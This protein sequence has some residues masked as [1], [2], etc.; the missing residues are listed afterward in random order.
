[1][2]NK[3]PPILVTVAVCTRERPKMLRQLLETVTRLQPV[4]GVKVHVVVVEN[5]P[6]IYGSEVVA[7]FTDR[8]SISY[9]NEPR[10]GLVF[11]RNT[12]VKKSLESGAEWI[13]FVDD[14]ER[15]DE[16][17]LCEMVKAKNTFSDSRAFAGPMHK[18]SAENATRWYPRHEP[19]SLKTGTETWDVTTG[20]LFFNQSIFASD[21]LGFQFDESFN[22]SGGEDTDIFLR[23]HKIGVKIRWVQNAVCEEDVVPERATFNARCSLTIRYMHIFGR[24]S[25]KRFGPILGRFHCLF[26]ISKFSFHALSYLLFGA[27]VLIFNENQGVK[28]IAT[29]VHRSC[30]AI[31]YAK[32]LFLPLGSDYANVQGH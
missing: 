11:A 13:G 1:M 2:S 28:L 12:A 10:T 16:N 3:K 7:E 17:W 21:D 4:P 20:N 22:L 18:L 29:A 30:S 31:G 15:M 9:F 14:D 8:L 5:G 24:L 19:I 32:S 27:L 6:E 25:Q 26:F 23:L